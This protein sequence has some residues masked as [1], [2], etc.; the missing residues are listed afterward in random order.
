MTVKVIAARALIQL[1]G[2]LLPIAVLSTAIAQE[3]VSPFPIHGGINIAG[4]FVRTREATA[5]PNGGRSEYWTRTM[6]PG[7]YNGDDL[8]QEGF[9]FVRIAINPA[10]L[11][12]SPALRRGQFLDEIDREIQ[13][14][15]SAGLRVIA[16][17]HFWKPDHEV[18]T[19]QAIVGD[20]SSAPS[21]AYRALVVEIAD[22][23]VRYPQGD[24][25]LELLNEPPT[26]NCETGW[27]PLQ[28]ALVRAVRKSAARLPIIVTGCGGQLDGL[29]ALDRSKI[30]LSD[31]NLIF[32][33]HFYEPFLFTHQGA[34][35]LYL[36]IDGIPYPAADGS[37][38]RA[39][40]LT[41]ASIDRLDL[42]IA[43][44]VAAKASAA[45][46]IL[47]YFAQA[48]GSDFVDLRFDKVSAWA[49]AN[50]ISPTRVLLG[51]FAAINWRKTDR[52]DYLAARIRWD[53]DVRAA[54]AKRG[55][56]SA[57]WNLPYPKGKIFR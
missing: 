23:L 44:A 30:D 39:V 34:Y 32:S 35:R 53:N 55:F 45:K 48:P 26:Q 52:P 46:E 13:F 31:S 22:R 7:W 20:G 11:L 17:L 40:G 51:E 6:Y 36:H 16:D 47:R 10:V 27:I 38:E 21:S 9:D 3:S 14:Y 54:A 24:V 41:N 2:V 19:E 33:F 37:V 56:A 12:E 28:Q 43:D 42:S 5:Y 29:L 18:W 25:A 50:G 15:R 1:A 4:P 49:R 8:R 57:Y